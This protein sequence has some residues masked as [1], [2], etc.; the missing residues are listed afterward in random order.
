MPLENLNKKLSRLDR[1]SG[2]HKR[3][4]SRLRRLVIIIAILLIALG[5]PSVGIFLSGRE[6]LN[7]AK[8]ISAAV[9]QENL[10]QV[11]DG[12]KATK[13]AVDKMNLSLKFLVWLRIIPFIGGYVADAGH[14]AS[15]AG[16]EL[17][18]AEVIIDNLM[19]YEKELGFTGQPTPGQDKIAQAVKILDK[20]LPNLD[21]IQPLMEKARKEVENI[22]VNKYPALLGNQSLRERVEEAKNFIIGASVAASEGKDAL[23]IAPSALGEPTPKTYL[24][25]FQNDKEIRPTGGFIT[26]FAF[27]T[28]DKGH[29]STTVSDDIY[30]LDEKLL[31]V[32]LNKICPLTPPAPIVKY[33]PEVTGKVRSAW[34]MRDSNISPDLP[35]AAKEFERMYELLG[36]GM[37]FD[38]IITI[39]TH[40]VEEL[41]KITGPVDIFGTT[42]S[43]E[44]DKRCNCPNVIYELEHYAEIAAQGEND[45]KAILGTLMQQILAKVLGS[46]TNRMPTFINAGVK[47]ANDKH[48]MIYMNDPEAQKALS[49]LNWTGEIKQ[50]E[51]DY[52]HINDAN[53]AG[54]KS[55]LYVEEKVTL[56]IKVESDGTAKHKLTIEYKNPQAYNTWLNGILR[57]YVRVYVS[58]GS[59]LTFNKGS[60]DPVN[61]EVDEGLQKTFFDAFIQVRPQNSRT[62]N[63][64]YTLPNKI[65]GKNYSLLIQKQPGAKDHHY[66][67]KINGSKKA[68]FDLT[69]DKQLNLSF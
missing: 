65:K 28:L 46:G 67:I 29:L 49:K 9:K 61:T 41:I 38:G 5:G 48:I 33:L 62:L 42:Y 52:L 66:V 17:Q 60:D 37:P 63:F 26:A 2:S 47:L 53:F 51:G 1:I 12:I 56:D 21:K 57:D 68:E 25:L 58:Q 34:S 55:N 31:K 8:Q 45:R 43:A 36:E 64:E 23:Q 11:R 32:C 6:A 7:G 4:K 14:F 39:D 16:Y 69:S 40:V 10:G 54:G 30:R 18:A 15:A 27:L 35:T 20:T 50:T 59:E 13:S 44:K 22:D 3:E 19:P 24:I